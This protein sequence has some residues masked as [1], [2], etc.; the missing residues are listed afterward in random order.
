MPSWVIRLLI[1]ALTVVALHLV[2][3]A[4]LHILGVSMNSDLQTI[5]DV[6]VAVI[7]IWYVWFGPPVTL[8]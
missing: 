6:T 2:L 7:A 5:V 8:R 1:A 4:F 3:P